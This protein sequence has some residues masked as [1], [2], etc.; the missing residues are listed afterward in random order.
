VVGSGFAAGFP[1]EELDYADGHPGFQLYD[2]NFTDDIRLIA[3]EEGL[4]S[5]NNALSV[6]LTG[7][8]ASESIGPRMYSGTGGQIAFGIGSSLAGGKSIIVVPSSS[9]VKG[10]RISRI[11]PSIAPSTV[12][13]LPRAFV[14][15]VV[16]EHGVATLKGKSLR[17]RAHELIAVSHP[18]FRAELTAEAK[19]LYG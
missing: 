8:V 3:R 14:H 15:Y 17:E 9:I 6:D 5:I 16:T 4:I 11:V 1:R 18:D 12:F 10:Q 19:R 7:Q 2:F 13:T